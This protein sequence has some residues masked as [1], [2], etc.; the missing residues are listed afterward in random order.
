MKHQTIRLYQF[1]DTI[2]ELANTRNDSELQQLVDDCREDLH[3][4]AQ[5]AHAIS[6]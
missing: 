1:L 6:Q 4:Q 2:E 3:D 5:A